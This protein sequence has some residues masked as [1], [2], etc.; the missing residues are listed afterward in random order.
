MKYCA[1]Q[2]KQGFGPMRSGSTLAIE[3]RGSK[4]EQSFDQISTNFDALLVSG[5]TKIDPKSVPGSCWGTPG[6]PRGPQG[7]SEACPARSGSGPS[8][9]IQA[10]LAEIGAILSTRNANRFGKRNLDRISSYFDQRKVE[11]WIEFR[12][13][14]IQI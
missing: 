8:I 2:Q 14:W 5:A 11:I 9:K 1:C 7:R 10:I 6:H 12:A 3:I 13:I 4:L